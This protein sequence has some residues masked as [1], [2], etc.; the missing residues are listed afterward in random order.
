MKQVQNR[1]LGGFTVS[2]ARDALNNYLVIS[3]DSSKKVIPYQ[4]GIIS[5]NSYPGMI[6]MEE[7][8]INNQSELYYRLNNNSISLSR[9][10]E[11]DQTNVEEII[12]VLDSIVGILLGSKNF[13]LYASS[14]LLHEEYIYLN[15]NVHEVYLIYIPVNLAGDVNENFRD[16]LK[17]ISLCREDFYQKVNEYCQDS[18]FSIV[19]FREKIKEMKF[20]IL[21]RETQSRERSKP[22]H[23]EVKPIE[24]PPEE[25]RPVED[26]EI[27]SLREIQN[28]LMDKFKKEKISPERKKAIGIFIL[29]QLVVVI[30]LFYF[31]SYLTVTEDATTT[32]G[33]IALIVIALNFLLLKK[34]FKEEELPQIEE[35]QFK[36]N[37]KPAVTLKKEKP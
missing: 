20:P 13:L 33:G 21:K 25:T 34:L 26:E 18:N 9:Y 22:F 32:Y 35:M 17:R 7:R 8:V 19:G 2:L 28:E 36:S 37:E 6:S 12:K 24:Q 16:L 11:Q 3:L 1:F 30:V 31:S 14:F 29:V 15:P 4:L 23:L 27:S 10:L 5:S